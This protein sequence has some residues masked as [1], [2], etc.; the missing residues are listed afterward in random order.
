[1][2]GKYTTKPATDS[3]W[4]HYRKETVGWMIDDGKLLSYKAADVFNV[5][6]TTTL[7]IF[8]VGSRK[9][10]YSNKSWSSK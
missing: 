3:Y 7:S 1:M 8:G 9:P 4:Q 2:P 6:R 5:P 10:S